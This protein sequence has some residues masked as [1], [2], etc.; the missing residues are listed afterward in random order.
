[1]EKVPHKAIILMQCEI[2]SLLPTNECSGKPLSRKELDELGLKFPRTI[3]IT[4]FDKT[5]CIQKLKSKLEQ[6]CE[7]K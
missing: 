3:S 7:E 4:G 5:D 2:H 1:M 6:L